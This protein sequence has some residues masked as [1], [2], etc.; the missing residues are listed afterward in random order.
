[1]IEAEEMFHFISLA[2]AEPENMTPLTKSKSFM[3]A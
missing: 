2:S 1:M 3:I